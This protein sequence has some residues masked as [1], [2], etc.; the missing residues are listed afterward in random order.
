MKSKSEN[1]V[2]SSKQPLDTIEV[3]QPL[4]IPQ[5]ELR[6][7]FGVARPVPRHWHEEYQLCLIESGGGE[8]N[9]RGENFPTPP[10][11]LFI[12]HPGEV[13]SN[14]AFDNFG[15][16]YQTIFVDVESVQNAFTEIQNREKNLPFFST[17][18]TFDKDIIEQYLK[19][20]FAF[21]QHSTNL[22]K[23]SLLLDFLTNLIFRF[24][25]NRPSMPVFGSE[26]Q[27]AKLA[28]DYL[29]EYF[30]ENISLENLARV[31][32]LSP[33]HFNRVFSA[34]YGVPP[35]VFQTQLRVFRA[36]KL[37]REGL[38]ISQ[39]A[40]QTGFADQSHLNR[41]FKRLTAVT[42]GQFIKNSKNIQD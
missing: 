10:A 25:E 23:Q 27:A 16:S 1:K 31:A 24:A 18:V 22:E 39:V 40:L 15:C 2:T 5:I 7:G 33:F 30:A 36:K 29:S 8:L 13:H 37:L 21:E 19:L 17:A 12:V 4:D 26:H 38:L 34:H 6:K 11:S 14:R 28:F 20:H 9:Y 3:W 42:P 41:H 32:N 35:H